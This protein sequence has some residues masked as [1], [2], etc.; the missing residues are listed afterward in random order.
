[1]P[2]EIVSP[3][4]LQSTIHEQ[5]RCDGSKASYEAL[6]I[7]SKAHENSGRNILIIMLSSLNRIRCG[8]GV[9]L[10]ATTRRRSVALNTSLYTSKACKSQS[11]PSSK[12]TAQPKIVIL[13]PLYRSIRQFSSNN[14]N[15]NSNSKKKTTKTLKDIWNELRKTPLQYATIPAVAAFLGLYTNYAGVKMLFYPIEYTGTQWYRDPAVPYGLFGWQGVVPCKTEKMASRLVQIVT[16]RLLT[17]KEAFG[18]IEPDRLAALLIPIVEVE[19]KKEPYGDIWVKILH[20][21]LP[22]VL[23]HVVGNLQIEIDDILDLKTVVLEAFVRDK[24]VLVDL[25]QKV[26]RV[27]LDFLVESG[28]GFGFILGLVQMIAWVVTPK[29]WTLPVAGAVVG[30]VTNWIA[31]E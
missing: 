26:G 15:P 31:S 14:N 3:I 12:I 4:Y 9:G 6:I 21:F 11:H 29:P 19:L 22:L 20:P 5:R 8:S 30:Y 10:H 16:E 1:M 7:I 28:L 23:T 25:F 27:E 13:S 24:V 18:R 17:V 2:V